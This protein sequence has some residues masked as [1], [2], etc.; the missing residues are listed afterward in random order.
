MSLAVW[1]LRPKMRG[2]LRRFAHLAPK[3]E[4]ASG[5]LYKFLPQCAN[6]SRFL[7]GASGIAQ[8]STLCV[9][10]PSA[11]PPKTD[12]LRDDF[13]LLG[14]TPALVNLRVDAGAGESKDGRQRW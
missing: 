12:P 14:W 10:R 3:F 13:V 9:E 7:P 5:F 1:P 2:C 6:V 8:S 11:I 4:D